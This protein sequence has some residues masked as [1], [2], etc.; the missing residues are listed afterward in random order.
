MKNKY[1]AVKCQ[2][3]DV[4]YDSRKEM[5]RHQELLLLEKA[6]MIRNLRRQVKY[7][8]IPAQRE[9]IMKNGVPK[10]GKVIE[11]E[12]SYYADFVY[13]ENGHTIV[14]DVKGG[15]A[16]KTREFVIKR[17]LMFYVH[18]IRVREV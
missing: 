4:V 12:C 9:V 7:I 11:R 2:V 3:G 13:E 6:G 14:E 16:T 1:H 15:N 5:R 17:K 18:G 8:L 10:P